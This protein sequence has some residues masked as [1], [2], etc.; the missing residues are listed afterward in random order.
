VS[1]KQVPTPNERGDGKY[2]CP[3]DKMVSET[4]LDFDRHFRRTHIAEEGL[5]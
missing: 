4:K 2:E 3:L 1:K 5:I